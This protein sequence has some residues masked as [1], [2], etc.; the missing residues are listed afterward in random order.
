[1]ARNENTTAQDDA[2]LDGLFAAAKSDA[3]I[4]PSADLMAR[5]LAD[6][7]ATQAAMA[8]PA[9]IAAAK[10][11]VF[12]QFIAKL[13]G[14]QSLSGLAMATVAGLWIGRRRAGDDAKRL[15]HQPDRDQ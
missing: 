11:S 13:G 1:M 4:Q 5:V 6:A 7:E 3:D 2:M 10:P 9:P 14:W 15:W 8:Q 12:K